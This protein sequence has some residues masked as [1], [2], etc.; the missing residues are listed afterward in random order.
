MELDRHERTDRLL[1]S[2]SALFTSLGCGL[3]AI[4]EDFRICLAG[5]DVDAI[6]GEGAA[7]ACLGERVSRVFGDELFGAQGMISQA[8]RA[9][10]RREDF[11]TT[12]TVPHHP[13]C[14]ATITAAPARPDA[15]E[16]VFAYIVFRPI[17]R[18]PDLQNGIAVFS[19]LV[20]RS[21]V[22]LRLFHLIRSLDHSD[23]S[24]LITG[25]G[26]T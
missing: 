3:M 24:V 2:S 19:G 26:G 12:I 8:L 13:P 23:A 22:M 4:D 7:A 18:K 5:P 9:G 25:E 16:Q 17:S 20:A 10:Q 1:D 14:L 11:G 6:I 15:S 21:P